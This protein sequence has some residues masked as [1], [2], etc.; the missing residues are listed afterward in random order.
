MKD[1]RQINVL[2]QTIT[3]H[4]LQ[5]GKTDIAVWRA[6][7]NLAESVHNPVRYKLI[8][9]YR[10]IMLDATIASLVQKRIRNVMKQELNFHN[11]DGTENEEV[12]AILDKKWFHDTVKIVMET[13]FWGH[14]LAEWILEGYNITKTS[15]VPRHHVRPELGIIC[16]NSPLDTEGI[17]YRED[18]YQKT[19][20]EVETEDLGL[21]NIA[22][23]NAI[24]KRGGSIDYANF[25]EIFGSPLRTISYDTAYE[26]AKE[27]AQNVAKEMGNSAAMVIPKD[28]MEVDV[29]KGADGNSGNLHSQFMKDLKEELTILILGQTMTTTSGSSYNQATVHKGE[30]DDIMHD[31]MK[32]VLAVLNEQILPKLQALGILPAGILKWDKSEK[33][34]VQEK[35]EM[36]IKLSDKIAISDDTWYET[37]NIPKPSPAELKA[38]KEALK[39]NAPSETEAKKK[40]T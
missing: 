1:T 9:V 39:A 16:L 24:F 27:E 25:V 12:E 4:Q 11:P 26:N 3:V 20:F 28:S 8:E 22:A 18:I 32:T 33:L 5:R 14:S 19:C 21:L 37:F 30:Q 2:N 23:A 13:L 38:M 6:A 36:Y 31:D 35:L 34:T 29:Q 40:M 15:L 17:P 7:L 10:E